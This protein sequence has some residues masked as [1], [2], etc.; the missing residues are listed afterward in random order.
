MK[1]FLY[2]AELRTTFPECSIQQR[3]AALER[4]RS[5]MIFTVPLQTLLTGASFSQISHHNNQPWR[6]TDGRED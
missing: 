5:S 6:A 2:E 1:G 4:I 3:H